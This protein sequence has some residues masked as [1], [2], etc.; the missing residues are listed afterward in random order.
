MSEDPTCWSVD[1]YHVQRIWGGHEEGGWYY[2]CGTR[3]RDADVMQLVLPLLVRPQVWP[4][5]A[6]A[7]LAAELLQRTL[8]ES[9]NRH[10]RPLSSVLSTG[11][12]VACVHPWASPHLWPEEIPTYE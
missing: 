7:T 8:D 6:E 4:T 9:I 5:E 11:I 12:V 3:C 10:R 2:D 1:V